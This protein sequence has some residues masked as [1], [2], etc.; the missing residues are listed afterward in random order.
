MSG[1]APGCAQAPG[2]IAA[3]MDATH[4]CADTGP[5]FF[6]SATNLQTGKIRVLSGAEV[7]AGTILG[8]ACLPTP[9]RAAE[10]DD[11][12]TGRR[13]ACRNGG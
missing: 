5:A 10:S 13:E 2:R 7:P 11:K 6:V 9:F 4:V 8:P 3:R 12:A 1:G